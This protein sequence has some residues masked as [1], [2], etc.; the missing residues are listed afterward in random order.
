MSEKIYK[1]GHFVHFIQAR[2][3]LEETGAWRPGVIT[4]IGV[5]TLKIKS[6]D[7]E[8]REF[9]CVETDRMRE[10]YE[11]GRVPEGREGKSM[12]I[13][14]AHSVLIIPCADEGKIFPSQ[15]LINPSVNYL[16]DGAAQW[17]PTTDGAWH[18]FSID[19][20]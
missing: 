5:G 13:V 18:L 19:S 20:A 9:S 7:G 6:I 3:A 16:D 4:E 15:A 11:S 12:I 2:L 10:V 1:P 17:S 14:A 8:I